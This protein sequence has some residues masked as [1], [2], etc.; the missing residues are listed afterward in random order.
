MEE[1]SSDASQIF[2][3]LDGERIQIKRIVF[4]LIFL[5]LEESGAE[6]IKFIHDSKYLKSDANRKIVL[7]IVLK[8]AFNSAFE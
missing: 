3:H 1:V 8:N 6:N 7:R 4:I 5:Q 2:S